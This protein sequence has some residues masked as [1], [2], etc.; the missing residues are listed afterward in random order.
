[1]L[2]YSLSFFQAFSETYNIGVEVIGF[3]FSLWWIFVPWFLFIFAKD[4]W[5]KYKRDQFIRGIKWVL[6]EVR[7]PRDI[8][9]TPHAIEQFFAGLHGTQSTPNKKERFFGGTIQRWFSMEII[10]QGGEIRFLVR[11]PEMFRNLIESHLYA[12]YPETEISEVDDYI[13]SVPENLPN[14]E[15]EVWG[16]ELVLLKEDAY[17]IR[18]Y[19]DFEKSATTEE[20]RVDPIASLLEIMARLQPR[21]QIWIQTLVRPVGDKW[22]KEGEK[23]RDELIGREVEKKESIIKQEAAG[24]KNAA[25]D[26]GYSVLTGKLLENEKK[27]EKKESPLLWSKTKAEQD[28]INA[29]ESNISKLGFETI[30][31]FVY[32]GPRD[33]FS[34]ANVAALVGSFKQFNTQHLNGFRPSKKISPNIDYR[35][36]LKGQRECFRKRKVYSDYRW[37]AFEP[38]SKNIDYL[39]PLFFEKMPILNWFFLRSQPFIFNIEELA[40]IYHFPAITVKAPAVPRVE[41]KKG[42]PPA[43]LPMNE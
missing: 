16:T 22:K 8:R 10:S 37:R 32:L 15:Y 43:G 27:E 40:T 13:Y 1:M 21:E 28:I 29:I 31:R 18:T 38:H 19:P 3:I 25:K 17:P 2:F 23:V 4:L 34:K 41:A 11:T 20:Q 33:I 36:Q 6:L 24:W 42:E 14:D 7:P 9:K 39:Q 12:Q 5:I 35:Y 30:V 26:V